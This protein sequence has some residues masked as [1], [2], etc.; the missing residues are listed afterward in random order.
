MFDSAEF[1]RNVTTLPGVYQMYAVDQKLLYVGKAKNLKKRLTSYFDSSEKSTKTRSMM[2]SVMD[3]KVTIAQSESEALLLECNLIKEHRPKYNILMRDDKSYPYILL[4]KHAYPRLDSYRGIRHKKADFYGPFPSASA[5]KQTLKL[6]QKLFK[7]RQCRDSFFKLRERPCLQ[8]Q[9]NRCSAPCV[10]K[11][12]ESDYQADVEQARLLLQ[13][14]SEEVLNALM[15]K[16]DIAAQTMAYEQAASYRDMIAKLRHIQSVQHVSQEKGCYDIFAM[17]SAAQVVCVA[18]LIVRHGQVV[19]SQCFSPRCPQDASNDEIMSGF[20]EQYYLQSSQQNWIYGMPEEVICSEALL[21]S[22]WLEDFLKQASGKIIRIKTQ[23]RGARSE[24]LAMA[25]KTAEENSQHWALSKQ[26]NN[27]Q[28]EALRQMLSLAEAP[29]RIEC[30]DISHMQ[31]EAIVGSCVVF[32]SEG[33]LKQDY[34]RFTITG[35]TPG[36]D[37]AAMRQ[38]LQRRYTRRLK[39]ESVLPDLTIIDGGW[40]QVNIA[41]EVLQEVGC[42]EVTLIGISKGPERRAGHEK[43]LIAQSKKELVFEMNHPGFLLLQQIRDEAHRFAVAGHQMARKKKR[44]TSVLENIPGIGAKR[45]RDLLRH[46]GGL[47]ALQQAGQK[48]IEK[49]PGISGGLAKIIFDNLH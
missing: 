23:V 24:W 41:S 19:A 4:S 28:R 44:V 49:V 3:V 36:D 17:I 6:I 38:V 29:Q 35:I 18:M 5:V 46:F 7:L 16:M 37:Y 39:E 20:L 45:R 31:G 48:D 13:G 10:K 12:S 25:L 14:K 8:Y 27:T 9:I 32:N 42:H 30:F 11:I 21:E 2:Q 26:K 43:I 34:R 1:L 22:T 40:G 47:Q 33:A 15:K